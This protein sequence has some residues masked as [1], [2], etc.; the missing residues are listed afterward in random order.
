L[1]LH[2]VEPPPAPDRT[3]GQP[4]PPP[5]SPS[6]S[7]LHLQPEQARSSCRSKDGAKSFMKIKLDA[8]LI[9]GELALFEPKPGEDQDDE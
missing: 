2:L 8:F 7:R 4:P 1:T 9:N 3:I 5:C 6:V